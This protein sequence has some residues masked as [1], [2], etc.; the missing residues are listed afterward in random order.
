MLFR[1]CRFAVSIRCTEKLS[2][3]GVNLSKVVLS[4]IEQ[5]ELITLDI[6]ERRELGALILSPAR[7]C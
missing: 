7:F 6:E 2:N 1:Q 3:F 4:S 5:L